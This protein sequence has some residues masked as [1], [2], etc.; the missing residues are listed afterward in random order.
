MLLRRVFYARVCAE[1]DAAEKLPKTFLIQ[2]GDDTVDI[3]LEYQLLSPKCG[4]CK[5]FGQYK[6][7]AQKYQN[8]TKIKLLPDLRNGR[9]SPTKVVKVRARRKVRRAEQTQKIGT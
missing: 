1:V 5:S 9:E 6:L 3:G 7:N 8:Q 2:C 4:F